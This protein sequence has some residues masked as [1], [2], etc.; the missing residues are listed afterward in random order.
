MLVR[1][2]IITVIAGL[3][4]IQVSTPRLP[5]QLDLP[6]PQ[7]VQTI[8]P[9]IGVHTRL[10]GIGDEAYI[11]TNLEQVREMGASWI[12]ELFPWAYVQP[13][14]RYGYDWNGADLVIQHAHRQGLNI[15]ARLDLVP[16]WARPQRTTIATSTQNT[17]RITPTMWLR[18][19][20]ATARWACA[21]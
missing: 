10:T 20:S 15:V 14:S 6:P 13:R 21:T 19:P 18:S 16:Q 12:V 17:T 2:I 8:N 7:T 3:I 1:I 11:R 5:R 4:S 9:K